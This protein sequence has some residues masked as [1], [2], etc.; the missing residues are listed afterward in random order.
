MHEFNGICFIDFAASAP[1]VEI[2]M[3]PENKPMGYLDGIFFS[4]H[5]F[6]G[7]PGSPGVV[8]FNSDLYHNTVPD[9]PGGG[10]VIWTNRW[11][12]GRAHV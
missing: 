1:Y 9:N 7:G 10:T 4:P 2:D 6:L 5:K 11:K 8:I 12:I 3:H